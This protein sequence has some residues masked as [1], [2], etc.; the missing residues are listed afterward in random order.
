MDLSTPLSVV[1]LLGLGLAIALVLFVALGLLLDAIRKSEQPRDQ[2]PIV[3]R[4]ES[5]IFMSRSLRR[6]TQ[7]VLALARPASE[8]GTDPRVVTRHG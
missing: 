4:Q 7:W 1:A 3:Q 5:P 6:T 2:Q 8:G